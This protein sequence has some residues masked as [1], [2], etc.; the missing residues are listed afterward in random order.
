VRSVEKQ[1]ERGQGNDGEA[2]HDRGG[3]ETERRGGGGAEGRVGGH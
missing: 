2:E 1:R 3:V